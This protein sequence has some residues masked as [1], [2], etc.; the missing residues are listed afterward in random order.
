MMER[1]PWRKMRVAERRG[2]RD[3]D[4]SV[5]LPLHARHH[6]FLVLSLNPLLLPSTRALSFSHFRCDYSPP[7][8]LYRSCSVVLRV[9]SRIDFHSPSQHPRELSTPRGWEKPRNITHSPRASL[10]SSRI[11]LVLRCSPYYLFMLA[12]PFEFFPCCSSSFSLRF[13][14]SL[15]LSHVCFHYFFFLPFSILLFA[16]VNG[17]WSSIEAVAYYVYAN[18]YP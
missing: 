15:F 6:R 18:D 5:L 12:T 17:D 1:G 3:A 14:F 11:T 10:A 13:I 4:G 9:S 16:S 8:E 7:L 2:W